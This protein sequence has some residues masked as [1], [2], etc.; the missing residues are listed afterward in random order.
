MKKLLGVL[1]VLVYS[2]TTTNDGN[3]TSVV[4]VPPTNLIG[5]AI[6]TTEAHLSWTDNSTNETGFKIE[7]KTGTGTYALAGTVNADMPSFIDTGLDAKITYIYRVYSYN[8][9][10]GSPTY[11][12]ELSLTTI[13]L[14]ELTTTTISIITYSSAT[15]GGTISSDGGSLITARG[16][17]WSTTVAPTIALATKTTDGSGLGTFTSAI[18][19]ELNPTTKYYVRAYA[20]NSAGTSYGPVVS[21]TTLLPGLIGTQIWT[22]KNL[23]V[24]TYRDGTPIPQVNDPAQWANLKTGACCSYNNNPAYDAIYGKL[25]NWYAVN[26]RRGLAPS[27]YH[28]PSKTEFNTLITFLGRA[29][30]GKLKATTNWSGPNTLATNYSGFKALPGGTLNP[31]SGYG[32]GDYSFK[33]LG[34]SNKIW[35]SSANTTTS[36]SFL[37]LTNDSGEASIASGPLNNGLSVR[38][39]KD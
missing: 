31:Y 29:A 20:T 14:A 25:Y 7:R 34:L 16:I 9:E 17:V 12:N 3:T 28:I 23:D 26:D 38:C 6:S 15:G 21:F 22:A 1:L 33:E 8:K 27:G 35:S 32:S 5:E 30:G 37:W 2:C 36:S 39:I 11:S 10:G 18:I 19:G 24:T 4:P 13:G